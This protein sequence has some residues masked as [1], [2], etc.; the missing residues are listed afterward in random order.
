MTE[1]ARGEVP[2]WLNV[3]RETLARMEAM[4][5]LVERWT[6]AINLVA[7]GSLPVAWQ[8]HVLDSAQLFLNL[9]DSAR[10]WVDFGS[11]AGFPGLVVAILAAEQRPDLRVTLVESDKRKAAFLIQAAR[12]LGLKT[13]VLSRRAEDLPPQAADVVSARALASLTDL[14]A[15]VQPHLNSEGLALFPKGARAQEELAEAR[16]AWSFDIESQ[17]SQTDPAGLVLKIKNLQHV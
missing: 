15:L 1:W 7:A 2:P 6:P 14:L 13:S 8:R 3:S 16:K 10:H 11:G 12:E 9:P 4:L 17:P 5:A